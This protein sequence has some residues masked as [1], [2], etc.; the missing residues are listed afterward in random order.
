MNFDLP[1]N[2]INKIFIKFN[3]K[4]NHR[5]DETDDESD[6]EQLFQHVFMLVC[7]NL[8]YIQMLRRRLIL[9]N[10]CN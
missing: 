6:D 9:M 3:M 7:V 4:I 10:Y 5:H 8:N 1:F 2:R